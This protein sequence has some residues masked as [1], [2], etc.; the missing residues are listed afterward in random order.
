M[1]PLDSLRVAS[2]RAINLVCDFL[3]APEIIYLPQVLNGR[4]LLLD[5]FAYLGIERSQAIFRVSALRLFAP[6]E[7]DERL[8][9]GAHAM[10]INVLIDKR[11]GVL[12]QDSRARDDVFVSLPALAAYQYFILVSDG[13]I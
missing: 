6:Q 3:P 12:D 7:I 2:L 8:C 13:Y 10:L 11:R 4:V 9:H 5:L 1:Q